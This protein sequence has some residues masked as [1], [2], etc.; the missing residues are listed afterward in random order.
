MPKHRRWF[1][2][3]VLATVILACAACTPGNDL[4]VTATPSPTATQAPT[5]TPTGTPIPTITPIPTETPVPIVSLAAVGDLMLARTVGQRVQ[6]EG[7]AVVFSGVQPIFDSVDLVVGNLECAITAGGQPQPKGYTF[8]APLEAAQALELAGF[9]LL[10]LANNHAMDYGAEGLLDTQNI[11]NQNG[12]A[13]T[14]TGPN[15]MEARSPVILEKNGL[16]MAFLG[17]VDVPVEVRGFDTRAWIATTNQPGL[18]WA[19]PENIAADVAAARLQS[20][21]V[22]VMLHSGYEGVIEPNAIQRQAAHAAIDAGA[23]LVIGAHPHVLQPVEFYNGG[24]IAYS[25]GNFVFD[26]FGL[27][28]N[29]TAILL[30]TLGSGG[31]ESYN[32][33]PVS[34]VNGL[35]RL[36]S[37]EEALT[38]LQMVAPRSP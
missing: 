10:T 8:A 2:L 38:I 15:E 36:A 37:R 13:Y 11:L 24:L 27:E 34:I 32:W 33:S 25:L 12:I 21:V 5:L 20:D 29:L 30:V 19:D 14:G 22:I 1:S 6:A 7:P 9:D 28:Q 3:S 16:R 17:Y 23:A 18:A 26:D 35:P 31:V 4:S